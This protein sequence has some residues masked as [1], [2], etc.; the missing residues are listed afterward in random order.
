[1]KSIERL[2]EYCNSQNWDYEV[3]IVEGG[4]T[5]ATINV[6]HDLISKDNRIKLISNK[7]RLGKGRAIKRG[8]FTAEKKYIGYMDADLSADP[9]ELNR[10]LLFI[11]QFD[12]VI[13]SRILRGELP[14]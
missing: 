9:S 13:G 2:I 7:E 12:I 11:D 14:Q 4:S 3:V 5:D 10:L 1:L 6:I 8:V